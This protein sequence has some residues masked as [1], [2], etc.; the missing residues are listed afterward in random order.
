VQIPST[1]YNSGTVLS[2]LTRSKVAITP[3]NCGNCFNIR[4]GSLRFVTDCDANRC[5]QST[6]QRPTTTRAPYTQTTRA[7]YT[8]TT[9]A[10]YTQTTRAPYVQ[11]TRAPYVQQTTPKAPLCYPGAVDPRC[12]PDCDSQGAFRDPRCKE[13]TTARPTT[14]PQCYPGSRD[15]RCPQTTTA[16]PQTTA[17]PRRTNPPTTTPKAPLCYPGT[18][19]SWCI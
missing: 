16:R 9:R 13:T 4:K 12:P 19:Y 1:D 11:T 7:P 10:P 15:S 6:T 2:R 8:Q 17:P 5:P 18:P 3:V 14:Q